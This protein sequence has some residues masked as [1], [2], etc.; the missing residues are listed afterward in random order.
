MNDWH[1]DFYAAIKQLFKDENL[2]IIQE[3]Y[4]SKEPLRID[5]IIIKN[6]DSHQIKKQIGKIFKKYNIIEYKSPTDYISIDDYFKGLSYTYLYKSTMNA[7]GKNKKQI[8]DIN[9][10]EMTLSFV[11][12]KFPEKLISY[13]KKHDKKIEKPIDGIY[14][15][16]GEWIPVQIIVQSE[17]RNVE[18][19][20][21]LILL[22]D[23]E[24][25]QEALKKYFQTITGEKSS[26]EA[27]RL[28]EAAFR[29]NI[30]KAV[31]VYKM[32]EDMIN[33][34]V[35][36]Y[37]I[38]TLKQTRLKIYTEQELKKVEERGIERGIEKGIEEGME[39]G[40]EEKAKELAMK[41]LKKKLSNIPDDIIE[42]IKKT[43]DIRKVE[44]MVEDIFSINDVE[45]VRKY[46]N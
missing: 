33:E 2:K 41:L 36:E 11:C 14:Y 35:Q 27:K 28:L 42:T 7:D 1:S 8:N 39:K 29:K 26:S 6:L 31:E 46:L 19:N 24:Y 18:E 32:Y 45:D 30:I 21:A 10:E 20:F 37:V 12:N 22:S 38:K 3:E 16:N 17:I 34:E 15:I 25:F 13:L 23:N 40:K 5:V 4:L 44:K 9:I 43:R